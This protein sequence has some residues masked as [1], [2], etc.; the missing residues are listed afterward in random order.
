MHRGT[1]WSKD[2]FEQARSKQ[3]AASAR[4]CQCERAVAAAA[5]VTS[6]FFSTL[7]VSAL[8]AP[9]MP[10]NSH[11]APSSSKAVH[12]TFTSTTPFKALLRCQ[13]QCWQKR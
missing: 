7:P 8:E 13:H 2:G 11:T 4:M 6:G 10:Y 12:H 5:Q 3:H 9:A 1:T